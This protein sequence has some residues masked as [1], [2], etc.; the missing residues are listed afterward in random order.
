MVTVGGGALPAVRVD[1]NPTALNSI[2]LGLEDVRAA[3]ASAN[4]N[5]PKGE[6]ASDHRA[7][8]LA[9]TDQLLKAEEYRKLVIAYRSGA[10]VRL[11]DVAAVTDSLE[12]VRTR[13]LANGKPAILLIVLPARGQHHR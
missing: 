10:A 3:L 1:V 12:D 5:R 13:R 4:A 2:G 8:A 7:W 6:L 11:S 9:T